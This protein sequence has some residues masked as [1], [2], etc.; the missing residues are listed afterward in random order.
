M[1]LTTTLSGE[2]INKVGTAG[3]LFLRIPVG[4]EAVA[5]GSAYTGVVNDANAAFWNPAALALL[6]NKYDLQVHYT[7]WLLDLKHQAASF[8]IRLGNGFSIALSEVILVS[9]LMEVT[10]TAEQ[11]GTGD[12]FRYQDLSIGLSLAK[13]F[14]DKFSV[15]G[16]IKFINQSVYTVS[17]RGIAFDIGTWYWTGY[18]DLRLVMSMKN[19]GPDIS[20]GGKFLDTRKK[21]SALIEDKLSYGSYPLPLSFVVGIAGTVYSNKMLNILTSIEGLYPND[22]SQRI[23]VGVKIDYLHSISLLLG[24]LGNYEQESIGIG[25]SMNV[26]GVKLEYGFR[27]M[28]DFSGISSISV[29][30]VFK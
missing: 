24:Y 10:T 11:N 25:I 20:F 30:Y 7:T 8:A 23:H 2:L 27:P 29:G 5:M 6:E 16:T 1:T 17:A 3:A 4:A 15:G 9:P 19:F 22:Y 28:R 12:F 26:K 18:R 13:R 14:T 21:G